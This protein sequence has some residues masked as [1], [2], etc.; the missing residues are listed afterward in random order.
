MT[1]FLINQLKTLNEYSLLYQYMPEDF[2]YIKN[3]AYTGN[4]LLET[5]LKLKA[6][7][8]FD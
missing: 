5:W 4:D 1:N 8:H 3:E 7:R 6:F 2:G